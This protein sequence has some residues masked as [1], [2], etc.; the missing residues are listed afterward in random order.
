MSI[1]KYLFD[2]TK[3]RPIIKT[4]SRKKSYKS[5]PDINNT[6]LEM[7]KDD[8]DNYDRDLRKLTDDFK[9][10]FTNTKDAIVGEERKAGNDDIAQEIENRYKKELIPMFYLAKQFPLLMLN[11]YQNAIDKFKEILEDVYQNVPR[12]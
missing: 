2:V 12:L 6:R 4:T 11:Y 8:F 9:Q 10:N 5:I 3:A 7:L 1:N